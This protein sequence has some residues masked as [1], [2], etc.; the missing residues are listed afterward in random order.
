MM[1]RII[2]H[3]HG[4]NLKTKDFLNE[5]DFVCGGYAKEKLIL[6]SSY[7]KVKAKSPIFLKRIQGDICE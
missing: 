2:S 6:R 4:H 5:E 1:Q 3:S 7:L